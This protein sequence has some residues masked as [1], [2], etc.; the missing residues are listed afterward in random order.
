MKR[1]KQ[2]SL[3][4][5]R[6]FLPFSTQRIDPKTGRIIDTVHID[7]AADMAIGHDLQR[8]LRKSMTTWAWYSQLKE[9]AHAKMKQ[10]KY[11]VHCMYEKVYDELRQQHSKMS[12]TQ[13][14][15]KVHL[16]RRWRRRTR[17]YMLWRDR[18]RMLYEL[19]VAL[20]ERNDNLR[21]LESS[22]RREREGAY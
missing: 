15:N 19:C 16:D 5:K 17:R 12:E 2:K 21:T 3:V 10:A 6:E 11:R 7:I 9:Q 4:P 20:K 14:K 8:A 13:V 1:K 18:Y 22:E